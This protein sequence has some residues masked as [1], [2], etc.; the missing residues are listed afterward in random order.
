MSTVIRFLETLGRTQLS[1]A[2][3]TAS[4]AALDVEG[5]HRKALMD[6]DTDALSGMLGGRRKLMFAVMAADEEN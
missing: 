1:A 4:V 3:Y 6:K 5:R 2:E